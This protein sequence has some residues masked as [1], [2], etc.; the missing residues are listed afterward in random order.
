MNKSAERLEFSDVLSLEFGQETAWVSMRLADCGARAGV[1][2]FFCP[3]SP[4]AAAFGSNSPLLDRTAFGVSLTR[5]PGV[6]F[7]V[8]CSE[9][10]QL[11]S[12]D[13]DFGFD[14]VFRERGARNGNG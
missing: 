5:S 6:R 8:L 12:S 9:G 7:F 4:K 2:G 1:F 14:F 13:L 11:L 10:Q 3:V